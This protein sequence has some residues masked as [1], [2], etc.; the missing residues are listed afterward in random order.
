VASSPSTLCSQAPGFPRSEPPTGPKPAER[1]KLQAGS[2]IEPGRVLSAM[3]I[4]AV[5]FLAHL[6]LSDGSPE[7]VIG[8]VMGDFVKGPLEGRYSDGLRRA[9]Q[10]HRR[11]DAY[12]DAHAQVR[13]SRNRISPARRRFA[14][15]MVDMFYD[16]FLARHWADYCG[17]PLRDFAREAYAVLLREEACL[18][19]EMRWVA[20]RMAEQDW[21]TSYRDAGAI[22]V[23]LERMS[24]RLRRENT[25]AGSAEELVANYAALEAD[26]RAFFPDVIGFVA[27]TR[28]APAFAPVA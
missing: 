24:K 11:V 16:H 2:T 9:L 17:V 15:I 22:G 3:C 20:A 13:A 12:T 18:T 28:S 10:L 25:L 4:A 1:F 27:S 19:A 5:N 21:L 23:A 8:S 26:F 7:S 6:F 14:G